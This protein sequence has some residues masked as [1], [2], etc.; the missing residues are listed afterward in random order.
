MAEVCR[1]DSDDPG[2]ILAYYQRDR[3]QLPLPTLSERSQTT[4]LEHFAAQHMEVISG[5][6]AY[7]GLWT[8]QHGRRFENM[9]AHVLEYSFNSLAGPYFLG[10]SYWSQGLSIWSDG[11][12]LGRAQISDAVNLLLADID[13]ES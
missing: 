4:I 6:V 13:C 8:A 5:F 11:T 12:R 2:E 3:W 9:Y 7:H 1:V 10:D